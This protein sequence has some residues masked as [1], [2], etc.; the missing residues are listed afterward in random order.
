MLPPWESRHFSSSWPLSNGK[1]TAAPHQTTTDKIAESGGA[2]S[3]NVFDRRGDRIWKVFQKNEDFRREMYRS[4]GMTTNSRPRKNEKNGKNGL[5]RRKYCEEGVAPDR[6]FFSAYLDAWIV[7]VRLL[8]LGLVAHLRAHLRALEEAVAS[9]VRWREELW[10]K[11]E[12]IEV[13]GH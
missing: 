7:V 9:V 10:L 11:L 3:K 8:F 4:M 6:V 12:V 2:T 13:V 5:Q 1:P